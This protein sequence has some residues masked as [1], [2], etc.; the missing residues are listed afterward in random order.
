VRPI[1]RTSSES[2]HPAR[3]FCLGIRLVIDSDTVAVV[4]RATSHEIG[5]FKAYTTH[6][7]RR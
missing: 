5:R 4:P 1:L 6:P 7:R 2:R 3:H